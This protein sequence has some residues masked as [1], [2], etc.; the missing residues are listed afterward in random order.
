MVEVMLQS[1][2]SLR[3]GMPCSALAGSVRLTCAM[4]IEGFF[5]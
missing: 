5:H 1:M 3:H 4:L 2:P